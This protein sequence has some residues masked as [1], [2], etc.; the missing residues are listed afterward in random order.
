MLNIFEEDTSRC[1]GCQ[2][3]DGNVA[4]AHICAAAY[5]TEK[6]SS[7]FHYEI[8]RAS[9]LT[10]KQIKGM[11]LAKKIVQQTAS[12]PPQPFYFTRLENADAQD[13]RGGNGI[14]IGV[15]GPVR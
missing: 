4:M 5:T 2:M 8:N 13:E 14:H 11:V 3:L 15:Y 12:R 10:G 7:L 1:L 9:N 6:V